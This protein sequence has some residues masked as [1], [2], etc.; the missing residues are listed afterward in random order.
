MFLLICLFKCFFIIGFNWVGC[1]F[2][3]YE[4]VDY[5]VQ[6]LLFFDEDMFVVEEVEVEICEVDVQFDGYGMCLDCW[7]V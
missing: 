5:M 4:V 3:E 2:V 6:V 1:C 7:F